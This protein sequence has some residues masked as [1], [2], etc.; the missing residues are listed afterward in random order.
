MCRPSIGRRYRHPVETTMN[1]R[2]VQDLM[3]DHSVG[4]LDAITEDGYTTHVA[5]CT[6]CAA[7]ARRFD[8]C[9]S[10][11]SAAPRHDPPADLWLGVRARLELERS[12]RGYAATAPVSRVPRSWWTGALTA[13]A[14]FACALGI[15]YTTGSPSLNG[16]PAMASA[17]PAAVSVNLRNG[18][19]SDSPVADAASSVAVDATTVR[20]LPGLSVSLA[21]FASD[22]AAEP[23]FISSGA[24][25]R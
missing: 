21:R 25:L 18:V 8:R 3:A 13:A 17:Q 20:S 11:I 6:N 14:G 12:V 10:L 23:S 5:S 15:L 4:L 16:A 7:E 2:Q 19:E 24:A 22:S 1:C 9:I